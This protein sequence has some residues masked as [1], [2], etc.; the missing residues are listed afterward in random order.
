MKTLLIVLLVLAAS[1]AGFVYYRRSR[2]K[3]L[4]GS[5]DNDEKT[6]QPPKKKSLA[7]FRQAKEYWGVLIDHPPEARACD[8]VKEKHLKHYILSGEIPVIPLPDCDLRSTCM[9][10]Y[11]GLKERRKRFRRS[12]IDRRELLRFLSG[13]TEKSDKPATPERR[14]LADRRAGGSGWVG[15]YGG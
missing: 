8:A 3:S 14:Q 5:A 11:S 4:S 9:C 7:Y 12:G 10:F 1:V 13:K 2:G 6:S 15:G